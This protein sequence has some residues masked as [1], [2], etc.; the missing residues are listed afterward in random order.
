MSSG[1]LEW[2]QGR[3]PSSS[4]GP[5]AKPVGRCQGS[6]GNKAAAWLQDREGTE[7][8]LSGDRERQGPACQVW[9]PRK[10]RG[11]VGESGKDFT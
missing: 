3:R 8:P 2:G 10:D 5:V 1:Y 9:K 7:Q 4:R 11:R 6:P